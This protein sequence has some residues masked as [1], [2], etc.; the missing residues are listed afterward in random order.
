MRRPRSWT[1]QEPQTERREHQDNPD[2]YY[3][4][5]PEVVPEEQDVHADHDGYQR[6]HV[7]HDGS[8]S[9]HGFVLLGATE[10]SKND[11]GLGL[12]A[13]VTVGFLPQSS[14][15][16]LRV[17]WR[18]PSYA[19]SMP[20]HYRAPGWFTR[21]V[22]N[23]LVAFLTRQGISVLGSRVPAVKGRTSGQVRTTPRKECRG[24]CGG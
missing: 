18:W 15:P 22:F 17:A 7:K 1:L 20:D 10:W 6:Q 24:G 23:Q 14:R 12:P 13:D 11:A 19:G 3:Q 9:S 16:C 4:P 2:I 5:L 21:N 8:L